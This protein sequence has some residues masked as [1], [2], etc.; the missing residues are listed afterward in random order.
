MKAKYRI[1]V[2]AYRIIIALQRDTIYVI[3]ILPRKSAYK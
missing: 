2:G 3:Q 1:R